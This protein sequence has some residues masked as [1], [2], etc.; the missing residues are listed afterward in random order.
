M[1]KH[2]IPF[3]VLI[4]HAFKKSVSL[5]LIMLCLLALPSLFTYAQKK[6]SRNLRAVLN[7]RRLTQFNKSLTGPTGRYQMKTTG[8]SV[9]PVDSLTNP[10]HQ[11]IQSLVGNGVTVSNIVT[12]IPATSNIIGSFT[13]GAAITGIDRGLLMTTGSVFNAIGPNISSS[14]SQINDLP[15]YT[16]IDPAGFDATVISFDVKSNSNFLSFKY[17]FASEEY[18]EYVGSVFNDVFAFLINGPGFAPNTNIAVLPNST[19]RVA[20]N[21]V[22]LGLNSIYYTNNEDSL[23]A[24]PARFQALEYDGITKVLATTQLTVE[25]GKTYTL[26]LIIQDVSDA[27]WDSGVFIEGGSITSD[28]CI[29]G[30]QPEIQNIT[31]PNAHDGSIEMDYNGAK[32]IPTFLWSTGDTTMEI[33]HLGP[34]SYNVVVTDE[35]GCTATLSQPIIISNPDPIN[36]HL[37]INQVNCISNASIGSVQFNPTGG[38]SPYRYVLGPDTSYTGFYDSLP[39]G[40]YNYSVIDYNNCSISGIFHI[41]QQVNISI[42]TNAAQGNMGDTICWRALVTDEFNQVIPGASV[43][44]TVTGANPSTSTIV[45]DSAGVATYC[46]SGFLPGLDSIRASICSTAA[47]G[48]FTW[49][50]SMI[51]PTAYTVTGGGTYCSNAAIQGIE[52]GL[53]DSDP[54]TSYQLQFDS[55]TGITNIGS[56]VQ[57]TGS[58]ISFGLQL[59]RTTVG[60]F[61]V[62]ATNLTS[63]YTNYMSNSV[64]VKK[65]SATTPAKP[66]KI[67][68]STNACLYLNDTTTATYYI[69][70]IN[71]A[72]GYQWQ[73]KRGDGVDIVSGANDTII[74]VQYSDLFIRDTLMVQSKN[75][76]GNTNLSSTP[77]ILVISKVLPSAPSIING[78]TDPCPYA[79]GDSL[80]RYSI[81][82]P[83][84]NATAYVWTVPPGVEIVGTTSNPVLATPVTDS[85]ITTDLL[86]YVNWENMPSSGT[87]NITVT[88]INNCGRGVTKTKLLTRLIPAT[89]GLIT[90]SPNMT[91]YCSVTGTKDKIRYSINKVKNAI[92]YSWK[93]PVGI[94]IIGEG[95]D[96]LD[97]PIVYPDSLITK[98]TSIVVNFTGVT[99]T[100][101]T[102]QVS[103]SNF[104]ATSAYRS[105][106]VSSAQLSAPSAI[107]GTTAVCNKIGTAY[108][109]DTLR[110][111]V[112]TPLPAGATSFRWTM[113]NPSTMSIV[114]A[115]SDSSWIAV[116]FTYGLFTSGTITVR[117]VAPCGLSLTSKSITVSGT[118]LAAPSVLSGSTNA[119]TK[120][121]KPVPED[122]IR[123]SVGSGVAGSSK[124]RWAL[125]G[126]LT[127]NAAIVDAATDSSWVAV[128]YT[129][130]FTGCSLSVRTVSKCGLV[131]TTAKTIKITIAKP[132]APASITGPADICLYSGTTIANATYSLPLVSGISSYI[133]QLPPGTT[134]ISGAGTRSIVLHFDGSIVADSISVQAVSSCAV[135]AKKTIKLTNSC[136]AGNYVQ[137]NGE[138]LITDPKNLYNAITY[139]NP[140]NGRFT[141]RLQAEAGIHPV[142]IRIFNDHGI[143]IKTARKLTE[144]NGLMQVDF[145]MKEY[146][147]GMYFIQY[148]G[149][150]G[151]GMVKFLL[152]KE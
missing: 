66:L 123:Y 101:S 91:N 90:S 23:V 25:P 117:S 39:V 2:Y 41:S 73:F 15:G 81:P 152:R 70:S 56:P 10:L 133:W 68:G 37:Q 42:T 139:P 134:V 35:R 111:Q 5:R 11:I 143:Q 127:G 18:N 16:S 87:L 109:N 115:S 34:G 137:R 141:F 63:L 89:P 84:A 45:T 120:I 14:T 126:I 59:A 20:I 22:N 26:T 85:I 77:A 80:A 51:T 148:S 130:G 151:S 19:T 27:V 145:D 83:L 100:G 53:A 82:S 12:N 44:F 64:V 4:D 76:C 96:S 50:I 36:P 67:F 7:H 119:C 46:Y 97:F 9:S 13:G 125:T 60:S 104:C 116:R 140:N 33:E 122:T 118:T 79:D 114:A 142:L 74:Q 94:T 124:Y 103:A 24:D 6:P 146:Q 17:A 88:P 21:N 107:W 32:G 72:T 106:A 121:G 113:S 28:S 54:N 138:T 75:A 98:D 102:I 55:T 108:P 52:I 58:A 95:K 57:G 131:S 112:A 69:N 1:S 71:S 3:R 99:T 78:P 47:N 31:C 132:A 147:D 150:K 110:Y 129:F 61:K 29:L 144:K 48:S 43:N 62:L 105:V 8:F 65:V 92:H 40:A 38:R 128:R 86:I 30:L 136:P 49:L 135:G 149:G 93:V